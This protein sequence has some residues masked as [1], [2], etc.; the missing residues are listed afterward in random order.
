MIANMSTDMQNEEE[1]ISTARF[2]QRCQKL[3]NE[4]YQNVHLDTTVCMQK[5]QQENRELRQTIEHQDEVIR[6]QAELLR[7]VQMAIAGDLNP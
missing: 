3:V 4:L 5:L 6:E 2:A 7:L 1:T